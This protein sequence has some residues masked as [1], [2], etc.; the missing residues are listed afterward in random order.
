MLFYGNIYTV[1]QLAEKIFK[2]FKISTKKISYRAYDRK[3]DI[4]I[5]NSSKLKKITK[6]KPKYTGE[7]FFTQLI[8]KKF[9]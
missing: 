3:N 6:W 1:K 5:G 9:N 7:K 8:N 2:K 4:M